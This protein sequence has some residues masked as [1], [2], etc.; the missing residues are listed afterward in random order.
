MGEGVGI[1]SFS[2]QKNARRQL[3]D[4]A[5]EDPRSILWDKDEARGKEM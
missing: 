2:K 4:Q 1:K 5:D 3:S